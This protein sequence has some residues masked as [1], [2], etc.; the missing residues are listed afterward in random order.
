VNIDSRIPDSLVGDDQRLAQVVTNLLSNA[1]KF[2]PENGA[3][4]L[5]A[6]LIKEENDICVLQIS[7]EDTGI[8]ISDEQSEKLFTS[9]MQAE[10][11]TSRRFGGTGLGLAIS[12][13]IVEMMN[14]WIWVESELGKGSKFSFTVQIKRGVAEKRILLDPSITQKGLDVLVVDDSKG[15]RDNL[16]EMMRSFGLKCDFA[17]SGEEAVELIK[18][19]GHYD[20]CFVDWKMSGIDGIEAARCIKRCGGEKLAVVMISSA[21]WEEIEDEAKSAGINKFLAKP[22][23]PSVVADCV[24]SI[25]SAADKAAPEKALEEAGGFEGYRLLLADDV[26]TNQEIVVAMLEPTG[27][28]IDCAVNGTETLRLFAGQPEKYDLIFM[29]VQMPEMDGYEAT[30]KIR[31]MDSP[32]AREVPIIAMTANVFKEDVE[33]CIAAGMNEHIG[34]PL[35]FN[36]ILELLKKYLKPRE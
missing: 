22:L 10:S 9:F 7:V 3:I 24:N 4:T 31:A 27:L 15:V 2:T 26:E 6:R 35:D 33:K 25:F 36:K 5:E 14:G 17:V 32:W 23:F 20:L 29:D 30:A 16:V 34:K 13:R 12:K 18:G 11:S 8:G 28:V 19:G 21:E 1:V